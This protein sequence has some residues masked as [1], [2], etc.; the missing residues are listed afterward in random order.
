MI[1]ITRPLKESKK[2]KEILSQK[3]YNCHVNPLSDISNISQTIKLTKNYVTLV[4]SPRST[5]VLVRK[6]NINRSLPLLVIG[7]TS[8]TRLK[9]KGFT[10]I[11]YL[12]KDSD[13][14]IKFINKNLLRR[15]KSNTFRGINYITGSIVN[16]RLIKKIENLEIML[17]K[18]IVYETRFNKNL[19]LSTVKLLKQKKIKICL[20][21]SQMNAIHLMKLIIENDLK[22][23]FKDI[24]FLTLSKNISLIIKK[25]GFKKVVS[26]KHPSQRSIL[27][28]VEICY[29][30]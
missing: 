6:K 18:I 14:L 4:T 25:V 12:A 22:S 24:Q 27:K 15:F 8:Y 21:Y 10:N 11:L 2:L 3:G 29:G 26:S 1:L 20:V 28:T 9:V 5:E 16:S 17:K 23:Q 13:D 30:M 19:K 7:K